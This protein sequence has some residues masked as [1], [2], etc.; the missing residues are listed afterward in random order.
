MKSSGENTDMIRFGKRIVELRTSK[1][2]TQEELAAKMGV[3]RVVMGYFE[4]DAGRHRLPRNEN[5]P[6]LWVSQ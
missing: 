4:H 3:S 2:V 6:R 5:W 1:N